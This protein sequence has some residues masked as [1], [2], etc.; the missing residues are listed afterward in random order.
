MK[1]IRIETMHI[2]FSLQPHLS[3][4]WWIGAILNIL[5]PVSLNHNTWRIT[6]APS[7]RYIPPTSNANNGFPRETAQEATTAPK[8]REPVSP[9]KIFAGWRLKIKK[10]T[11]A[12]II[13]D[14]KIATSSKK[15]AEIYNR[16]TEIEKATEVASPSIPSVRFAQLII[17]TKIK[18]EI[19]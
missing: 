2:L 19:G 1:V 11:V 12:P 17:P 9:I 14:E 13:A 5:F 7:M 4:W 18:S 8:K 6:E 15:A 10:P 3:R 16:L